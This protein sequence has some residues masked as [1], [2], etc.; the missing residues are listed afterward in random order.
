MRG[1]QNSDLVQ[2]T[3]HKRWRCNGISITIGR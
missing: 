1:Q 2:V 3:L